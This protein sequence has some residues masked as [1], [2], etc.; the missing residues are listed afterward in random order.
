MKRLEFKIDFLNRI[1]LFPYI[2]FWGND[3]YHFFKLHV[4]WVNVN[5]AIAAWKEFD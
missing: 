2:I 4:G 3:R 5:I 1:A